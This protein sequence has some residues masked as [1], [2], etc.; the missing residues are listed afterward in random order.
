MVTKI[1]NSNDT[2][3]GS[4]SED[5][6]AIEEELHILTDEVVDED[7]KEAAAKLKSTELS[8]VDQV[9]APKGA[10]VRVLLESHSNGSK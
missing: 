4:D 3:N 1:K 8:N 6:Y 9:P 7:V 10:D 5:N 2:N